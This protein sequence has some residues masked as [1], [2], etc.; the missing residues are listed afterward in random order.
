MNT[1]QIHL[2]LHQ[3]IH[4]EEGVTKYAK[5]K[6]SGWGL[7][8]RSCEH[9]NESSVPENAGKFSGSGTIGGFSRRAQLH[10]VS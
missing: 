4:Y 3:I 5:D 10:E 8:E 6:G 1:M 9:G 2:Q 7:V